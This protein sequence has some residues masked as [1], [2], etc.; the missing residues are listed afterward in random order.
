MSSSVL[1]KMAVQIS[2][3][4]A[5]FNKSMVDAGKGLNKFGKDAQKTQGIASKLGTTLAGFAAGIGIS[6]LGK[7]IFDVTAEFQKLQA[8]LTNTLGSNSL[9]LAALNDIK[10]FAAQTPFGVQE[11]TASFVKLANQ[12]FKPTIEQLR[13]LGD[14]AA[15]QGKS[16]DQLT[17][18]IIDA[19]TGEFERLKEFGIRASKEGDRVTFTF[20]GVKQQVDFTNESIRNYILSLGEAEGVSGSMA[21]ISQT[22][23]GQVS[24]LGDSFDNLFNALGSSS[25]GILSYVLTQ[26]SQAVS[27]VAEI[28]NDANALRDPFAGERSANVKKEF[29]D[30]QK[31]SKSGQAEAINRM[32]QEVQEWRNNLD[33]LTKAF[34][35]NSEAGLTAQEKLEKAAK[36][37]NL[38]VEDTYEIFKKQNFELEITKSNVKETEELFKLF[39]AEYNKS[40]E[41]INKNT[42]SLKNNNKESSKKKQGSPIVPELTPVSRTSIDDLGNAFA[43]N[44]SKISEFTASLQQIPVIM[45]GVANKSIEIGGLIASGIADIADAFG[46]SLTGGENFGKAF[47]K[48]LARFAQQFGSL[49]IATGVAEIALKS[50]NPAVMIAAGAALV[51]LGGAISA[52]QSR[53]PSLSSSSSSGGGSRGGTY[54]SGVSNTQNSL[55]L[56]AETV[57]R[58]QDLYVILSNYERNSKSTK[59]GG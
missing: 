20:K 28:L 3:N 24:N 50:G 58:G 30:F 6:A 36:I 54:A 51:A 9:A 43:D 40:T 46:Q 39:T 53:K 41:A 19:Q 38:S 35:V 37:L 13:Q 23:G 11:L 31:L 7:Q 17:E 18:A 4:T 52:I 56:S 15:S 25:T 5:S 42:E 27:F 22:L 21:A 10:T 59:V 16:F 45:Q 14:I 33:K 49:L 32:A 34:A 1:A 26:L 48:A 44:S 29:E 2:G 47:I 55:Q 12:G 57:I 8:V